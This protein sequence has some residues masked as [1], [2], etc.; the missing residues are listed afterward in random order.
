MFTE[1]CLK[2]YGQL[3]F[4]LYV[5]TN[6]KDLWYQC[7]KKVNDLTLQPKQIF[8]RGLN[9]LLDGNCTQKGDAK[10]ID[11]LNVQ[12]RHQIVLDYNNTK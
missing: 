2:D 4:Q 7:K 10:T 6:Q 8:I 12:R 11:I 9:V 1:N 3:G 5:H